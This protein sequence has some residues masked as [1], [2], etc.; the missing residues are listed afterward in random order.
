[1]L[2]VMISPVGRHIKRGV[3]VVYVGQYLL[4]SPWE[5]AAW[6]LPANMCLGDVRVE[7]LLENTLY[8]ITKEASGPAGLVPAS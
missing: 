2:E 6:P 7:T 5:G 4:D 3:G 8:I 1:M